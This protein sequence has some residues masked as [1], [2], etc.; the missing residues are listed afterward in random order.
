MDSLFKV[1]FICCTCWKTSS[2]LLLW[3]FSFWTAVFYWFTSTNSSHHLTTINP[4]VLYTQFIL[5]SL[6]ILIVKFV[7]INNTQIR[8]L[9]TEVRVKPANF[10]PRYLTL[11]AESVLKAYLND[12]AAQEVIQLLESVTWENNL[13][14]STQNLTDIFTTKLLQ[15][16]FEHGS[17]KTAELLLA[18]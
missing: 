1:Y 13:L 14:L 8:S 17:L 12:R 7:W 3:K 5:F 6:L 18:F 10:W 2:G 9:F 4:A 11:N 15:S 16:I